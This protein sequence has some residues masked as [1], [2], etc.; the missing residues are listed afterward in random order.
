MKVL[1]Y[2][3]FTFSYLNRARVLFQ[4][5]RRFHPDW[6]LVALMVDEP[7]PGF[8]FY[9][10]MEPFDRVVWPGDL[11]IP[12][13]RSWLFKHDVIEI[14]TAVKGPFMR[15]ACAAGAHD[16]VIYLDPDTAL[17]ADL[18]P[19][20]AWLEDYDIL[21]TPHL[22]EP[23]HERS[24]ILD[25]DLS[26]SKTGIFNLGFCAVRTTGE[27]ARFADWWAERLLNFCYDDIPNGLFVDQRWCDH[28]PALFDRLKVIRDPG[29]NVASWNLSTRTVA[30]GKDGAITVNGR[31]LRFWHFTKLGPT[32]DAMTRRYAGGNF[33]VYEIWNWYKRQID[34]TTDP[35]IPARWWAY[36]VYADGAAIAKADRVLYRERADLQTAFPDPF[37]S[38][39]GTYQQWL[40]EQPR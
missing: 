39:L 2:S 7:P 25:N 13:L 17:L 3:S 15:Q 35:A 38:G 19:L 4:T 14:S 10:A 28:A 36:G 1:C 5:V 9:P 32:G 40:A 6:E 37:Q 20:V 21:L 23:N 27:G 34:E 29:Y 24:A 8:D 33:E 22:I 12:N 30:I 31:P 26:A 18:S 11:E 16:A